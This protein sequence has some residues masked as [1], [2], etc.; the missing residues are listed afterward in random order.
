MEQRLNRS[1]V[2]WVTFFPILR[3]AINAPGAALPLYGRL[4]SPL[5][6]AYG[7][8]KRVGVSLGAD[9]VLAFGN[10]RLDIGR[11]ELRRCG[12][13]VDLEPKAFDLLAYLVLNR[14]RVVSKDDMLR[15]VWDGRIVSESALTTRINAV[16]QAVGDDGT[17]QRL[18]RTFIRKG[19][20]FIGEVTELADDVFANG[21]APDRLPRSEKPSLVVLPFKNVTGDPE[22]EYFV[23]GMVEEITT[24]I[25]RFSR[26]FVIARN[27]R[28]TNKGRAG[29]VN[30]VARKLGVRYLLEG[31]VRKSG[32]R[33]RIA[34]QLI[35][36]ATGVQI[37][38]ERFDGTLDDVF[39]LQDRV[40][41]G[42]AGAIE[43]KLWLAEI[44]RAGRKP[45]ES[46]DAYDFYL[47]AQAQV[48]KRTE[49]SMAESVRLSRK[50]LELDPGY[51]LA[52]A[53]LGLSQMMRYQRHWIPAAGR[54]VEEGIRMARQAI[55]AGGDDPLVLDFAG[56]TLSVLAG[57]NDAALSALDHAI[58]L[59]PNF[60]LAFG[61]RALVLA[62]LNQPEEAISSVEQAIRLS[63]F[64]PG[65]FSF[66][67]TLGVAHLA[68]GRYDVA[69]RWA[70]E[71]LR[72]NC[73]MPAL[74][75]KL[76]L[77]GHLGR[78]DEAAEC[79]RRLKEA[80]VTP[81]VAYLMSA[82]GKGA[83]V[84]LVA[85]LAEG[86]RKAGVPEE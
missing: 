24:A 68:A 55:A 53:R 2:S 85:R 11:R 79:V 19:I 41:S 25:A 42:V 1:Q 56:L 66:C 73:G 8:V 6:E 47:R 43:P 75:L 28:L 72:E 31:S 12:E 59:N 64:D 5:R 7:A 78:V 3:P 37:W 69:L 76:S 40:A 83:A 81:T 57:D 80:D 36:S 29:D 38:A 22:Q 34:G 77:C 32:R 62:Y 54:E 45:T 39:D 23:Y 58:M 67:A 65:M 27:S 71:A 26:L 70:E 84:A 21:A 15:A 17:A 9:V 4:F 35:D 63:P 61:H 44:E 86:L 10:H 46:L 50:A 30:Q 82:V 49:Q 16:R 48:F 60:A 51:A 20:R 14:D 18:V 13:L 74:R 52:M 33:V